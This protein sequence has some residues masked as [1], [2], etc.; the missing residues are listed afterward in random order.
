MFS[1]EE[2]YWILKQFFSFAFAKKVSFYDRLMVFSFYWLSKIIGLVY[3]QSLSINLPLLILSRKAKM[4]Q[5]QILKVSREQQTVETVAIV[6]LKSV[7]ICVC[8]CK[9]ETIEVHVH[10]WVHKPYIHVCLHV[11][12]CAY[13]FE[14]A[15]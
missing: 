8:V 7:Y 10:Q 1:I 3:D 5:H 14:N 2:A 13:V 6:T 12:I 15:C 4:M 9:R 11:C